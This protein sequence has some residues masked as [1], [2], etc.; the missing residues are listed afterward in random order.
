[1][2]NKFSLSFGVVP[3]SILLN[4]H[5]IRH[6]C[7]FYNGHGRPGAGQESRRKEGRV[8]RIER[9]VLTGARERVALIPAE[10]R[11]KTK[12]WQIRLNTLSRPLLD[13]PS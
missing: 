4:A 2:K 11:R 10:P 1:M 8:E 13:S 12:S 9:K 6:K 5:K 7:T 3:F